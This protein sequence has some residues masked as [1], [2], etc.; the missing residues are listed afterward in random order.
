MRKIIDK[1]IDISVRLSNQI[2]LKSLRDAVG[3]TMTIP[4]LAGFMTLLN[5]LILSPTGFLSGF[6]DVNILTKAQEIGT[7]ISNATLGMWTVV[8]SIAVAYCLSKNKEYDE[9][10]IAGLVSFCSYIALVPLSISLT[11]ADGETVISASNILTSTYTGVNGMFTGIFVGLVSTE[12]LLRLSK[13][14]KLHIKMPDSVPPMVSKSFDN[15]IPFMIVVC[16][17]GIFSFVLNLLFGKSFNELVVTIIQT[18]I[19]GLT[20]SLPGFLFAMLL[21]NLLFA[22]GIHPSGIVGAVIDPILILAI[23]ENTE[24]IQTGLEAP[25][26]INNTFKS[27]YG[28]M[29]GT[30]CTICLIIAILL[31]SKRADYKAV[32]KLGL[33][34]GI[35]N[36]NEPIIFG[37]PIVMNPIMIIPFVFVTQISYILTYAATVVGLIGKC[38]VQVPWTTPP[39]LN[40]FLST[41][42]DW[43]A[44][45]FQVLL[46]I[47][48][49]LIYLPFI[50]ISEKAL[51]R[52][53]QLEI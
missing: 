48:G 25:N 29:G 42:G 15:M 39:I 40:A 51:K 18:P 28:L 2:H 19:K 7:H 5:S 52:K 32:A 3:L 21:F 16:M 22:F 8:L 37:L 38:V 45:I 14:E 11:G 9:P 24:A 49:V 20:T 31:F 23:T 44:A 35:F 26:I 50:K 41:N 12:I 53:E 10:L 6:V 43:R 36:I 27:V 30:G 4:I 47:I 33:A 13:I 17:F 34:P 46:I 1:F